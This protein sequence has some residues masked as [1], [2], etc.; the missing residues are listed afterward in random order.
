MLAKKVFRASATLASGQVLGRGLEMAASIAIANILGP[1]QFGLVAFAAAALMIVRGVTEVS[2]T[3]A[4]V[5]EEELT[6]EDVDSGFTLSALRGLVTALILCALAWPI[7]ALYDD[8]RLASL[9]YMLA[10]APLVAGLRSPMM[11]RFVRDVNYAPTALLDL[12]TRMIAFVLATAT[13]WLTHSYWALVISLVLPSMLATPISYAIA[14]Y[15]PR[16]SFVKLRS[17]LSFSGWVTLTRVLATAG[18]ELDRFLIG[19]LLDKA[20]VGIFAMG[21]SIA[22]ATSWAL[23]TPLL[24]GTYPGFVRLRNDRERLV[25]AY[26]KTQGVLSA[27]LLPLGLTVGLLADRIVLLLLGKEWLPAAQVIEVLAP[28]GALLAF[29][30]PAHALMIAMGEARR[31]ALRDTWLFVLGF[32]AILLGT[33]QFGL[34]GAIYA[35]AG[36]GL[37]SIVAS[38]LIVRSSLG[39]PVRS[40]LT[41]GAGPLFAGVLLAALLVWLRSMAISDHFLA[42]AVTMLIIGATGLCAYALVLVLL[43]VAGGRREGSAISAIVMMIKPQFFPL[44]SRRALH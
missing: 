34:P 23:G 40:Q 20:A 39:I 36:M 15:R 14:P 5:R 30:M 7:G 4:L 2:V 27:A 42:E 1:T 29:T 41:P 12:G 13:A 9:L 37:A 17:L 8:A 21:R 43:W 3:E 25:S 19:A 16:I 44:A 18:A 38:I 35:R 10:L 11:V 6:Q 24:M 22:T 32:P 26:I 31:L 28:V 33:W